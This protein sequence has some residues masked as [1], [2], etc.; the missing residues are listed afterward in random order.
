MTP[1]QILGAAMAV[2]QVFS[3]M[4]SLKTMKNTQRA[5]EWDH[6]HDEIRRKYNTI[7]ANE[8]ARLLLSQKRAAQGARGVVIAEGSTLMEQNT[9]IANLEDVKFWINKGAEMKA[10]DIDLKLAGVLQQQAW[11]AGTSLITG[12]GSA[13]QTYKT[14]TT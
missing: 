4:G 11:D 3:F 13:Y 1:F 7:Q 2:G 8:R 5:A 14:K 12:M 6:Y 9:V 10:R